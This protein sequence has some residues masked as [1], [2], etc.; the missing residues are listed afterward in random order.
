MCDER[1]TGAVT[2]RRATR[3]AA[4][5]KDNWPRLRGHSPTLQRSP[6]SVV[7]KQYILLGETLTKSPRL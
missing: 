5:R 1:R 7:T 2:F 4:N 3:E 6:G